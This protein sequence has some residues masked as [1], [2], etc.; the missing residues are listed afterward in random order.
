[1][2]HLIDAPQAH[3]NRKPD[4]SLLRLLARAQRFRDLVLQGDGKSITE[5]ATMSSVRHPT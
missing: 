4:R 3:Q 2:R 1:M 5:L